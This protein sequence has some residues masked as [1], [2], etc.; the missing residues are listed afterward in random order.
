M[1]LYVV[2]F[3]ITSEIINDM[4]TTRE[5]GEYLNDHVWFETHTP[6]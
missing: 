3:L 2:I 1:W 5:F 4:Y 6:I